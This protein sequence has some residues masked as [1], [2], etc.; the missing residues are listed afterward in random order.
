[1]ASRNSRCGRAR[2]APDF[3]SGGV[4]SSGI[5]L[6]GYIPRVVPEAAQ[7]L[8][9]INRGVANCMDA[10]RVIPARPDGRPGRQS[11][12]PCSPDSRSSGKDQMQGS[13]GTGSSILADEAERASRLGALRRLDPAVEAGFAARMA[14]RARRRSISTRSST[15]SWSQS[16]RIS[17][18]RSTLPLVS[19]LRQS[20]PRERL[21]KCASPV[22]Q[23]ARQGLGVHEGQHQHLAARGFG[24]DGRHQPA[25]VEAGGEFGAAFERL[26]RRSWDACV[27]WK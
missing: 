15:Q 10:P 8:S 21:Q 26:L 6:V 18:T 1:M 11:I 22:A 3:V 17:T 19:P 2:L 5:G 27:G 4:L 24:D 12:L 7:R 23:R 14:G 25:G 16:V 13:D 20:A 9:G